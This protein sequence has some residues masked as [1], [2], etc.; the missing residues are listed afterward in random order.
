MH[1]RIRPASRAGFTLIELLVVIAIMAVLMGL[2]LGAVQKTRGSIS[3]ARAFTEINQLDAACTAFKQKYGFNPPSHVIDPNTGN[4][5]RFK[6]P[7]VAVQASSTGQDYASYMVLR[8]MFPR[9]TPN[10]P[11]GVTITPPLPMAGQVLDPN[12][13][14]VYFLAGPYAAGGQGNGWD[15]TG[16]F[17]PSGAAK[18]GPFYDDFQL[19][20]LKDGSGNVDGRY[21]DPWGTPYAYFSS[22]PG[23]TYDA[24]IQ[25]TWASDPAP[26][27]YALPTSN[28]LV[29]PFRQNGKWINGDRVQ[30]ISAGADTRFGAG[31]PITS[32]GPPQVIRD[33]SPATAEYAQAQDGYDD[34]ANFNSG[35]ILGVTGN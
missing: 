7:L 19:S 23:G 12:Q 5:V 26:N 3:R 6:V 8:R 18:D 10:L 2:L 17:I 11:D 1:R 16:P 29:H 14:M 30:I 20:R 35:T 21:R 28:F 4:A 32:A 27:T 15:K 13:A 33:W 34:C 31:S 22:N 25:F 9:W 24:R